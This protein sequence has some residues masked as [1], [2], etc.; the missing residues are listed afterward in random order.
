MWDLDEENG[1][2]DIFWARKLGVWLYKT[3]LNA[4]NGSKRAWYPT[5]IT[6]SFHLF[7]KGTCAAAGAKHGHVRKAW[8][9]LCR[10]RWHGHPET[11]D[12][13]ETRQGTG[14][15]AQLSW[16]SSSFVMDTTWYNYFTWKKQWIQL[17]S[18]AYHGVQCLLHLHALS[19][20]RSAY[21]LCNS[22]VC[23]WLCTLCIETPT[24]IQKKLNTIQQL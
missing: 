14:D 7:S 16:K 22:C 17:F 11:G 24:D 23:A 21:M 19:S 20:H 4:R 18:M 9:D 10:H 12:Q 2:L 13:G 8:R 6:D 5:T 1:D 3:F 15:W